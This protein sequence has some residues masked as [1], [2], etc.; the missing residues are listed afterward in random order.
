MGFWTADSDAVITHA[1]GPGPKAT[2]GMWTFERDPVSGQSFIDEIF[3]QS[4]GAFTYLGEWHTH[5]WGR[6]EPSIRD[7]RTMRM[8]PL[9]P[10]SYQPRPILVVHSGPWSRYWSQCHAY[11]LLQGRL[12]AQRL[13]ELDVPADEI[14]GDSTSANG[15]DG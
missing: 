6:L 14:L 12:V 3:E 10:R 2:H 7:L 5:P 13:Y 1:S 11:V 15:E 9:E 4:G 8:I